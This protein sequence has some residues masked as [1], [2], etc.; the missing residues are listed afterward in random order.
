MKMR[1]S[2]VIVLVLLF[3]C[4]FVVYA[5]TTE[6]GVRPNYATNTHNGLFKYYGYV[7]IKPSVN[8]GGNHAYRGWIRYQIKD[9]TGQI[10]SDSHRQYTPAGLSQEDNRILSKSY[11]FNDSL[12]FNALPTNFYYNFEW[13]PHSTTPYLW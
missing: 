5:G 6:Y 10:V 9:N 11:T 4:S 2:I 7:Q 1:K 13:I 8:Q 3:T 12:N